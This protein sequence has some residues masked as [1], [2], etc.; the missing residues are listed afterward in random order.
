MTDDPVW[1]WRR[2]DIVAHYTQGNCHVFAAAMQSLTGLP[3]GI[4]WNPFEWHIEP[5]ARGR[6]GV[7]EVIHVYVQTPDGRVID[8]KGRRSLEKMKRDMAGDDWKACPC[9]PL[10]AARLSALINDSE[11][12][13]PFYEDEIK[14]ALEVID[15]TP[16][17][18]LVVRKHRR[19]EKKARKTA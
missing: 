8:I 17:L 5:D 4:M 10:S 9:E 18:A 14:E 15:R 19:A 6:G 1:T 2:E 7:R 16:S 11:N 13:A 12:L 3:M